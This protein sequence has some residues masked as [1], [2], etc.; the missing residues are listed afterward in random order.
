MAFIS[1]GLLLLLI[2]EEGDKDDESILDLDAAIIFF[3]SVIVCINW[4]FFTMPSLIEGNFRAV[5]L[6]LS[7]LNLGLIDVGIERRF[8]TFYVL[9]YMEAKI[10]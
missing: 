1:K 5:F 2:V 10:S 9:F 6:L 8:L 4:L 3:Y 7:A